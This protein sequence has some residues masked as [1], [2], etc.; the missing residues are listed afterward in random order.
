MRTTSKACDGARVDEVRD[1]G[2]GQGV[3]VAG[4]GVTGAGQE[5]AKGD[6]G[7]T[8]QAQACMIEDAGQVGQKSLAHHCLLLWKCEQPLWP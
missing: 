4:A 3:T 1:D 2:A 8:F 5:G 7:G 6:G